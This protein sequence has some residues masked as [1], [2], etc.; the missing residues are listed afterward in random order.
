M[1]SDRFQFKQFSVAHDRCAMKVGTDG[2]LAGLWPEVQHVRCILDIG[3]G[4]GLIA[5]ILA[6]RTPQAFIE[7]IEPDAAA[8]GQ[9]CE[10]IAASP[11][12]ERIAVYR[13]ELQHFQPPSAHLYDLIVSNPPFF[14][15]AYLSGQPSRDRARHTVG[16]THAELL[17]HVLRLLA[18]EGRLALI[19]PVDEGMSFVAEAEKE[20]L[21]LRRICRV[22]PYA[23]K[24]PKRL[25][26]SFG[27]EKPDSLQQEELPLTLPGSHLFSEPYTR[28]A[29]DFYT[30]IG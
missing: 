25:L 1:A 9:A 11:W 14:H 24:P 3:T 16:L 30:V 10:N 5:L 4:T 6:Q 28:L 18:P 23:G 13:A 7:A 12:P 29:Q 22:L 19:L 21:F 15:R 26:L 17:T 8:F 20:G 27:Y 2:V